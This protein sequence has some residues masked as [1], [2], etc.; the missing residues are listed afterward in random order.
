M[1]KK[2]IFVFAVLLLFSN[3]YSAEFEKHTLGFG[4]EGGVS[5]SFPGGGYDNGE[6]QHELYGN[7]GGSFFYQYRFNR[8]FALRLGLALYTYFFGIPGPM[9][10]MEDD[11]F[12]TIHSRIELGLVF[13]VYSGKKVALPILLT[14]YFSMRFYDSAGTYE[15]DMEE[16]T[17]SV[18]IME[19]FKPFF[20]GQISFGAES[21]NPEKTGVG[22]HLFIRIGDN[23]ST[24][25]KP[26]TPL[27]FGGNFILF[28]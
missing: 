28:W 9:R 2:I 14:P 17:E 19:E 6:P 26:G 21:P 3:L 13:Y 27:S 22:F 11:V 10:G 25:G 7:F 16:Y 8:V 24:G 18:Q 20:G 15:K 23:M 5:G 1:F 12:G 4:V